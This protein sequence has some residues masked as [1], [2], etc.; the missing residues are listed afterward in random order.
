M[1]RGL[2]TY[3]RHEG[4]EAEFLSLQ[5][6]LARSTVVREAG[7]SSLP[8]VAAGSATSGTLVLPFCA[9][10]S[11]ERVLVKVLFVPAADLDALGSANSWTIEPVRARATALR[12]FGTAKS[13]AF[14]QLIALTPLSW[15]GDLD[16]AEGDLVAFRFTWQGSPPDLSLCGGACY[17]ERGS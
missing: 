17:L 16:L 13:L 2:Y 10:P 7:F 12:S 1:P 5:E 15:E 9:V 14:R 11:D 4:W 6:Q 8:T 3:S